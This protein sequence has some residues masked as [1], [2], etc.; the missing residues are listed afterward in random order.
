MNNTFPINLNI[1]SIIVNDST[2]NDV[3]SNNVVRELLVDGRTAGNTTITNNNGIPE[4]ITT[5]ILTDQW[6]TL[7]SNHKLVIG[8]DSTAVVTSLFGGNSS[9]EGPFTLKQ[10]GERLLSLCYFC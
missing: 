5:E 8:T 3:L 6:L 7:I 1:G 2:G 9:Y 10:I 4:T